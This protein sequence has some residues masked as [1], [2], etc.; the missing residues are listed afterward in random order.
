MDPVAAAL[1][2][3]LDGDPCGAL[4]R[5]LTAALVEEADLVLGAAAEHREAAVR[6]SPLWALRRAFTMRE[7]A[8]LL[9][10]ED[11]ESVTD[12]AERA[13]SLV[14]GAAARR[15]ACG[16]RADDDDVCDPYGAP[17]HVAR[18]AAARIA[19]SVE[20][21]TSALLAPPP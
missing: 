8:R 7:F 11:A 17:V 9:R 6:L 3:E 5:R 1:L 15:G 2:V 12:P 20:R 16:A 14:R 19:E 13:A 18:E 21:I 4:A 10:P